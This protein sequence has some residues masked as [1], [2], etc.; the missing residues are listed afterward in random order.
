MASNSGPHEPP[1]K[2]E[3]AAENRG[4]VARDADLSRRLA[5]LSQRINA[6]AARENPARNASSRDGAGMGQGFRAA[7]DLSGGVIV[8]VIIG[9]GL[10]R[11]AGSSPWGLILFVLVGFAAGVMNML[12]GFGMMPKPGPGKNE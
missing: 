9:L 1:A 3:Q 6:Q 5:E 8:G 7:A 11:L 10:D 12:R 2:A 4:G